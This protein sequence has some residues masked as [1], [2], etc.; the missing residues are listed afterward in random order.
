MASPESPDLDRI[1]SFSEWCKR[2]GISEAT[3]RRLI[4]AGEGPKLTWL[5][6]R[7][8]GIRER[9]YLEWLDARA[10]KAVAA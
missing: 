5:S 7:R 9:H 10:E 6:A 1:N 8:M 4:D 3:G 2:A